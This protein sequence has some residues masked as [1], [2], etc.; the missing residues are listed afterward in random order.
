MKMF[1][2]GETLN[3]SEIEELGLANSDC[4]GR[5]VREALAEG[6][7]NVVIDLSSTSFMDCTGIGTLAGLSKTARTSNGGISFHLVNP[8]PQV[9]RIVG[10]TGLDVLFQNT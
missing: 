1:C 9:R 10:L 6:V 7:K 8:A 3:I 4:F 2:E 5:E